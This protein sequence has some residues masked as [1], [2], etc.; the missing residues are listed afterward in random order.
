MKFI[1]TYSL[2]FIFTLYAR[3]AASLLANVE[4]SGEMGNL[5]GEGNEMIESAIM[6]VSDMEE[7][8]EVMKMDHEG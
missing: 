2:I 3:A 1:L 7:E 4:D 8:E 6:K 5:D